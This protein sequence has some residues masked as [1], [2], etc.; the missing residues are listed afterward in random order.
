M[1]C[2]TR[3]SNIFFWR[4]SFGETSFVKLHLAKLHLAWFGCAN[5][6]PGC[7]VPHWLRQINTQTLTK[8][9]FNFFFVTKLFWKNFFSFWGKFILAKLHLENIIW[10]NFFGNFISC[11]LAAP[12]FGQVLNWL[13]TSFGET[14]FGKLLLVNFIWR[15]LI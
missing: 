3:F 2:F 5:P 6:F 4:T 13:R 10:Q 9:V 1:V 12:I 7:Q 14:S 8:L 15:S 11:G